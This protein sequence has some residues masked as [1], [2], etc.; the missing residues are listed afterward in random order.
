MSNINISY[1]SMPA[2]AL[3]ASSVQKGSFWQLIAGIPILVLAGSFTH[4]MYPVAVNIAAMM[5]LIALFYSCLHYNNL[6]LLFCYLFAGNLFIFGN[7]YGGIYNVSAIVAYLIHFIAYRDP[8]IHSGTS[9]FTKTIK[10]ALAIWTISQILS[11]F[12]GNS[13]HTGVQV[14][15]IACFL[16]IIFLSFLVSTIQF[17]DADI[18]RFLYVLCVMSFY[19]FVVAFNQKYS[20]LSFELP[21]FPAIDSSIDF[22]YGIVRSGTTLNNFEAYAE[23]SLSIIALL[24]PG[25][26][27]GSIARR[28]KTLYVFCLGAMLSCGMAILLSGTRSSLLL[29]PVAVIAACLVLGKR[30]RSGFVIMSCVVGCSLFLLNNL[31]HFIDTQEFVERSQNIDLEHLTIQKIISG[32][33]MNRGGVF[34]YA[35]DQVKQSNGFFGRGYFMT[36]DEYRSVHFE[37]GMM[38]DNIADYHNV[39]MSSYVLWGAAGLI[40]ILLIF[41]SS[42]INGWSI[43]RRSKGRDNFLRD[44]LLGFNLLFMFFVL[45]Q[46]KI[47]FIRDVNYFMII[48]LLLALYNSIT[49]VLNRQVLNS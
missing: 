10:I 17:S 30:I 29:L 37:P 19:M 6:V 24:L 1:S 26:M 44:I 48:L 47:Q 35:M 5:T 15:A 43:Y 16:V 49:A 7:K 22:E 18:T 20:V 9:G 40:S 21:F 23:F 25:V 34:A 13:F 46:F 11:A 3:K 27:S 45:N 14:Q 42:I 28:S 39:F 41:F 32:E 36:P 33:E 38:E 4:G 12:F 2:N 8:I 31:Y